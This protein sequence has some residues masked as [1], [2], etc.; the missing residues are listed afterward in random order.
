MRL[1]HVECDLALT[2]DILERAPLRGSHAHAAASPPAAHQPPPVRL[3]LLFGGTAFGFGGPRLGIGV[4]RW[5]WPFG[6][7]AGRLPGN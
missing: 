6:M 5:I 4:G 3:I 1:A 7:T 2:F